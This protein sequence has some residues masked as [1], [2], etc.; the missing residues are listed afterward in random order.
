MPQ[1][2]A[3]SAIIDYETS[4]REGLSEIVGITAPPPLLR[5]SWPRTA[6]VAASGS[7]LICVFLVEIGRA[8]V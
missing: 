8:H 4:V 2:S 3:A 6:A 5:F 1:P 7:Y